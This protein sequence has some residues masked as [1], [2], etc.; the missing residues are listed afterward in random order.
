[1]TIRDDPDQ[2]GALR[3][4]GTGWQKQAATSDADSLD[5]ACDYELHH[6]QLTGSDLGM[7]TIDGALARLSGRR[8]RQPCDVHRLSR[9]AGNL[10]RMKSADLDIMYS[11]LNAPVTIVA[12]M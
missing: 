2:V 12:P 7:Q 3:E 1:M 8:C 9:R 10:V 4:H 6:A 5:P 11:K